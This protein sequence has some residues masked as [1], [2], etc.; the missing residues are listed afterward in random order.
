LER[1]TATGE[2]RDAGVGAKVSTFVERLLEVGVDG[3][4]RFES[5]RTVA[6]RALAKASS[7]EAA[8]SGLTRS[9][10]GLAAAG[11]FVT[12]LG[13]FIT[14]PVALPVNV[15]EFYLLATRAVAAVAH[16]R[17]YDLDKAEVRTAVLLTLAGADNEDIL[18]KAGVVSTGK[19]AQLAGQQ[20]PSSVLMMVNKGVGFRLVTQAGKGV[21]ARFGRAVPAL[22]G[23]VGA[24]LDAFLLSRIIA[25]AKTEFPL[26]AVA[27]T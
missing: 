9:H 1:A 7:R 11:G 27:A 3:R 22:G 6:D 14:M 19:I 10:V 25:V 4:G 26:Q 21:F 18:K 16:L 15:L 20:L 5:A 2:A 13:G 23:G 8:I 17:G 24:G 12:G